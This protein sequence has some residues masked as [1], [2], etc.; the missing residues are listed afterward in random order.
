MSLYL[1]ATLHPAQEAVGLLS[2]KGAMVIRGQWSV[3]HNAFSAELLCKAWKAAFQPPDTQTLL[4]D[5]VTPPQGQDMAFPCAE[6]A[7]IPV[8]PFLQSV[9][10]PLISSAAL[11]HVNNSSQFFFFFTG[12]CWRRTLSHHP[13]HLWRCQ[14]ILALLL[15]LWVPS[16]EWI[17]FVPDDSLSPAAQPVFHRPHCPVIY[18]ISLSEDIKCSECSECLSAINLFSLICDDFSSFIFGNGFL[19]YLPNHLLR[20]WD[21]ADWPVFSSMLILA[22]LEDKGDFQSSRSPLPITK[23]LPR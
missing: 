18:P 2:C 10:V 5:R 9:K 21:E 6:H 11:W 22:L 16:R 20:D 4:V 8:G 12:T 7:E 13:G 14:A 23:D 15:I 3:Q 1:L 19:D 17:D